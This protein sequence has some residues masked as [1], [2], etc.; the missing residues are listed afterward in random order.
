M[1]MGTVIKKTHKG[2]TKF[3][4]LRD[5][6]QWVPA[7][8]EPLCCLLAL[9]VPWDFQTQTSII[10][11]LLILP[12]DF[13]VGHFG[14]LNTELRGKLNKPTTKLWTWHI[15]L[16]LLFLNMFFLVLPPHWQNP[17]V[18]AEVIVDGSSKP[19][20]SQA[21][22]TPPSGTRCPWPSGCGFQTSCC[23]RYFETWN[24]TSPKR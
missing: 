10:K 7:R 3:K 8:G 16:R 18:P 20:G 23:G 5:I 24:W 15:I 6:F 14:L 1:G 4:M 22:L 19:A 9:L 17:G 12:S 21:A 13:H 2:K 11:P